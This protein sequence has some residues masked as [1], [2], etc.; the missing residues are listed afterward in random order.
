MCGNEIK[1][2][3][4]HTATVKCS[5]PSLSLFLLFSNLF[6]FLFLF[7]R[8]VCLFF[9]TA[10]CIIL[11]VP[12]SAQRTLLFAFPTHVRFRRNFE[13]IRLCRRRRLFLFV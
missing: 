10:V 5:N 2:P 3:A 4:L 7:N 6:T 11:C 9:W 1:Q 12:S 8:L 13:W